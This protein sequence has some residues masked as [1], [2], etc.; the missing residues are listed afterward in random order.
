MIMKYRKLGKWGI[1]VSEIALGSW[2]TDVSDANAISIARESVKTAYDMGVNF[3][4]CA[5]GYSWGAA[6][7]FLGDALSDYQRSSYVL[8]SKVFFPT[9]SGVNDRGLSRKHIFENV[10]KSLK[11]LKTDYLDMY[12]CHRYD[13][14]T[15]VEETMEAMSDLVK[16]GKVLYYGVSEWLPSQ[17]N[18]ALA[19]IKENHMRPLSVI[20]PQYNMMD[21]FIE[22]EVMGICEK[23]GIGIVAF[24]P[25]AQGLLTGKY[26]KGAP[27]PEGSRA[28]HQADKQINRLL[29]D[30]NLDKVEK[31]SAI[32]DSLNITMSQ[33]A[34]AWALR[35]PQMS[36]LIIGATKPEQVTANVPAS[37]IVLPQNVLDEIETILDYKPFRRKIG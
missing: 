13:P 1:K 23:N 15:P 22:D 14:E 37:G 28:T 19:V 35:K 6:E 27:L 3:F 36:S 8:S 34:L 17:I 26:K 31:L 29:T 9:G 2:M 16:M 24:S 5:D 10:D 12:F 18:E 25:L 4:D 7:R 30:E 20:Q 32:A 21:R 11:N 33:L